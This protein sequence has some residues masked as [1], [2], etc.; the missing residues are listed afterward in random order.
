[1]E[2]FTKLFHYE[3]IF[4]EKGYSYEQ[5]KTARLQFEQPLLEAFLSWLENQ[6]ATRNS[7]LDKALT[8][9]KNRKDIMF[10]YLEDGRC[11]VSNNASERNMKSFVIG[12]KAWLFANTPSGAEASAIVYSMVEMAKENG[13]NIHSYLNFLLKKRPSDNMSDEELE[14]LAPWGAAAVLECSN[15]K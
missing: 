14:Q 6:T 11:S 13:L 10:T 4:K 8:Y 7:K 2:Y 1:M 15:K 12:R 5:R 3:E 9:A